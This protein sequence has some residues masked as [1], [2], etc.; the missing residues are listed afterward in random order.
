MSLPSYNMEKKTKLLFT[1]IDV[2]KETMRPFPFVSKFFEPHW[3]KL[4]CDSH[5][6]KSS[7]CRILCSNP[8]KIQKSNNTTSDLKLIYN[9]MLNA[10]YRIEYSPG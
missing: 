1:V 8:E 5:P 4:T 2:V 3:F 9:T 6:E 10:N 7:D